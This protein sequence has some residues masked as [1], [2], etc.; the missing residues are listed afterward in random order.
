[1]KKIKIITLVFL[2]ALLT[3]LLTIFF[4]IRAHPLVKQEIPI[5]LT[6]GGYSGINVDTDAL[7][8]GTLLKNSSVDKVIVVRA[9]LADSYIILDVQGIPFVQPEI[10][11]LFLKQ[12]ESREV[13]LRAT[14]DERTQPGYYQGTLLILIREA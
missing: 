1:M 7:H 8:F 13:I 14:V 4:S 9:D 11:R 6:V 3:V 5:D 10:K 2:L 12:G